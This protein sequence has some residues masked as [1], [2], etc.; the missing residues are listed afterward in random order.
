MQRGRKD[1]ILFLAGDLG[2]YLGD[3]QMPLHTSLN[4]N[5]QLTGQTG[6]HAFF[7]VYHSQQRS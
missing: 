5:G 7:E 1:E 4:H 2:H 6:I 3:A